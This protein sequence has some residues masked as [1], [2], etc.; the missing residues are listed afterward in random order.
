MCGIHGR[1]ISSITPTIT[2][3]FVGLGV[4]AT[5][6]RCLQ[7]RNQFGF[8]DVFALLA[9]I[10]AVAM[11]AL[12]HPMARH[13]MGRDIWTVEFE[14]ITQIIMFTWIVEVL[15][16]VSMSSIKMVFLCLYLR[17]F[18]NEGLRKVINVLMILVTGFFLAFFFGIA[19]NCTPVLYVWTSWTGET[20]GKC[21][22]FNS[23]PLR[24][25]MN[26][27]LNLTK[28][29]LLLTMFGTG[30][31]IT[32]VS[33]LRLKVVVSFANTT[34]ATYDNV[35]TSYW[36]IIECFSAV[37]CV[38]LPA[39]RRFFRRIVAPFSQDESSSK[40]S[41]PNG[42]PVGTMKRTPIELSILK[43]VDT[44][45][46]TEHI[47]CNDSDEIQLVNEKGAQYL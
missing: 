22:N 2:S 43:T 37:I 23:L 32:I 8:E 41:D 47:R 12:E 9:L 20:E 27:S 21:L 45:I 24:E 30:F 17:I 33:I 4:A 7:F 35:P 38:N 36:S 42:Y 29:L 15:Y 34:N 13:G 44:T 3:V 26:L 39:V 6:M 18:P 14:S 25:I 46:R 19:F 1:D 11:G 28:K 16:I 40:A 31:F 10:A 5:L